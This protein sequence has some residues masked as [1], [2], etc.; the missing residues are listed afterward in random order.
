[1]LKVA[2]FRSLRL[3]TNSCRL[4][5]N[6]AFALCFRPHRGEFVIQGKKKNVDAR[7]LAREGHGRSGN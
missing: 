4:I 3:L 1:M 7:G 6:R 2:L 5:G